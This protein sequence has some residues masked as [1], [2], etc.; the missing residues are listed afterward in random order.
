MLFGRIL[1]VISYSMSQRTIKTTTNFMTGTA[2]QRDF[3]SLKRQCGAVVN[4]GLEIR[5]S[6]FTSTWVTLDK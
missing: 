4:T 6:K 1:I 2:A 3:S 5:W